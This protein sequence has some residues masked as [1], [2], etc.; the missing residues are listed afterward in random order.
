MI[1][2]LVAGT[3]GE[4]DEAPWFMPESPFCQMLEEAGHTL[5][6]E[7]FR[8]DTELDGLWGGNGGWE[9]AGDALAWFAHLYSKGDA[10][11]VITHSHGAQVAAYALARPDPLRVRHL[12]DVAGPVR[13]DMLPVWAAGAR[14]LKQ[15]THIY[16]GWRDHWQMRGAL[17]SGWWPWEIPREMPAPAE[18]VYEPGRTHG[19]LMDPALWR[20]R[21]WGE[22]ATDA[23][24][25]MSP[26]TAVRKATS[27]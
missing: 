11:D 22:G 4:R 27:T 21:G 14:N 18:N 15:W 20:A 2:I 25:K 26:H 1:T 13:K 12:V 10:V 17:G 8:W 23:P 5:A 6:P 16:T 24:H 19:N 9:R 7:P 3:W